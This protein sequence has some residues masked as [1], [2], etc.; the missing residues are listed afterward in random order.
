MKNSIM[1][2]L[3]TMGNG[4]NSAIVS[5]GACRFSMEGIHE[6][7]YQVVNLQSCVD[8]GLVI[9]PSTVLWWN[10]QNEWAR[11]VFSEKG[12]S[13]AESLVMFSKWIGKD[14]IVWGNGANFDNVIL[15]NAYRTAN[16]TQPWKFWNDR[17]YRTVKNL[18]PAIKMDRKGTHHNALDDAKNQAEHLIKIWKESVLSQG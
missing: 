16:L 7:F 11:N 1:L 5:I 13:L 8:L 3:G 2:D 10:K 14:A 18:F 9:D 12:D 15:S 6:E 4:S 17:C